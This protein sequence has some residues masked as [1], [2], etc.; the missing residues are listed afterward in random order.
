V[1]NQGYA[2]V[3]AGS[4]WTA[5]SLGT[6]ALVGDIVAVTDSTGAPH[7]FAS[8]GS[9]LLHAT[10]NG[11]Y[12]TDWGAFQTVPNISA[13]QGVKALTVEGKPN[14]CAIGSAISYGVEDAKHP[15]TFI[16]SANV[17]TLQP[18]QALECH[19]TLVFPDR[20]GQILVENFYWTGGM[21]GTTYLYRLLAG[22]WTQVANAAVGPMFG[23]VDGSD[24]YT[25]ITLGSLVMLEREAAPN[26][27]S[28]EA[29]MDATS[30]VGNNVDLSAFRPWVSPSTQKMCAFVVVFPPD[31]SGGFTLPG[32]VYLMEAQTSPPTAD[33]WSFTP[34][35]GAGP[36]I[37][38]PNPLL[39]DRYPRTGFDVLPDPV[40]SL[41]RL[42]ALDIHGN[43]CVAEQTAEGW[44]TLAPT[45][46]Q[47]SA[48]YLIN[49]PQGY[50]QL[51]A[52]GENGLFMLTHGV[53]GG[54]NRTNLLMN[55]SDPATPTLLAIT[56]DGN[57][58]LTAQW[59]VLPGI[60][61]YLVGIFQG[62]Q[63]VAAGPGFG[64]YAI[65]TLSSPFRP[66]SFLQAAVA[67]QTTGAF[68]NRL[69]VVVDAVTGLSATCV[70]TRQVSAQWT[71]PL[72][73][74]VTGAAL[75]LRDTTANATVAEHS[76]SGSSGTLDLPTALNPQHNYALTASGSYGPS[77]GPATAPLALVVVAPQFV[78]AIYRLSQ[79]QIEASLALP[80]P[81][82]CSP[83]LALFGNGNLLQTAQGQ[84]TLVNLVLGG[85]LDPSIAYQVR[86]Y[87]WN[88]NAIG[89]YGPG[90]DVLVTT[91]TIKEVQF[92][93]TAISLE[94]TNLPGPP[95]PT[96]GQVVISAPH[97]NEPDRSQFFI[98]ANRGQFTPT[99][100]LNP[101]TAYAI[102]VA[103][104]RGKS[105]GPFGP[106]LA[107]IAS[108]KAIATVAYDG[109]MLSATW[110]GG[111]GS[112]VTGYLLLVFQ[113]S[114]IIARQAANGSGGGLNVP[115][116]PA[117]VYT[118][119]LQAIG[120]QSSGPIS[121]SVAVISAVPGVSAAV[122]TATT[123]TVT[124]MPPASSAGITQY[125]A[126][127]YRG[128]DQ[129]AS[130]PP[131]AAGASPT[132]VITFATAGQSG[133]AVRV[134]GL[135]NEN[136]SGPLSS[137]IPVLSAPP[138]VE[139]ASIQGNTLTVAWR[140]PAAPAGTIAAS[141]VTITPSQG[142]PIVFPN[143]HGTSAAFTLD[144]N[145][146]QPTLGYNLTI[147]STGPSG[148]TPPSI[149]LPLIP[150]APS[151]SQ[152]AYD[153]RQIIATWQWP[154]GATGANVATGYQ[155]VLSSNGT[156]LQRVEVLGLSGAFTPDMPMGI[157]PSLALSV[158]AFA[159][160][161]AGSAS[162]A[163]ALIQT[164]PTVTAAET[165]AS[166][167]V[168]TVSW[169]AVTFPAA[170]TYLVQ[171]FLGSAPQGSPLPASGTSLALPGELMPAADMAIAVA[172]IATVAGALVTGP[173]GRRFAL[174]TGQPVVTSAD[175]D[176][177]N[178]SAAWAPLTGVAGYV[179]TV[180]NAAHAAVGSSPQTSG[181]TV[182]FP[183][184]LTATDGPFTIV[185]Q[186]VIDGGSG[187]P[188]APLPLFQPALF[189][190]TDLPGTAPPN[191]Y[192]AATLALGATQISI[193]LPPLLQTG[194]DPLV[195]SPVI[196]AFDLQAN[197]DPATKTAFPNVLVFAANSNVWTF[198][199]SEPIRSQLQVQ[200]I[201]FLQAAEAAGASK[202]GISVLQQ[203]ISR[204]MPQTFAESHYYAYGLNLSGGPGTG[205]IDLR[206][207]LVVRV[208]FANYTNVWSGQSNSWLNGFGGGSPADFD[209]ADSVSSAGDWQLSMDSFVA[210]LT[211]SGAMTV[212]PPGSITG[213]GASAGVADPADLFFPTFP[214]PFYRLFFP[215][216]LQ[217]PT[218]TGSIVTEANFALASAASFTALS[219]SSPLPGST[220]PLAYFRGR[221]VL[222]LMIRIRVNGAEVVVPLGTTVGNVLDR[223]G[224]RPPATAIQ[225][226]G[227][228]LERATGPGLAVLGP[229]PQPPS[230]TYD[231]AT[232]RRIRL[233]WSTMANYGGPADA[234]NLPLLHGDRMA[235]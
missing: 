226:T 160:G 123:V 87:W 102:A 94:W 198:I 201:S 80:V 178:V 169:G 189:V 99:P 138:V 219:S 54:W 152:A 105:Q 88:G 205:S 154:A 163:V 35:P 114:A 118:V 67:S 180:L 209:V 63:I 187:L 27:P 47:A 139:Q 50:S 62:T 69:V 28:V 203:A 229:S 111:D 91:P 34:F 33:G 202:W 89:P 121:P 82:G 211:A 171:L 52:V 96:G 177:I 193:Y 207:G 103:S 6:S 61:D 71:L 230:L 117:G 45:R 56:Y 92:S 147:V 131:V 129:V 78:S 183:L 181:T 90:S 213:A 188:S 144:A 3:Q 70:G 20:N 124:I 119:A 184:A 194:T 9:S 130:S 134:Q 75:T 164:Y 41:M 110:P 161:S 106:S 15:G 10:K 65:V 112:G 148:T 44:G 57:L 173:Y 141:T 85:A 174:P 107:V 25:G 77:F 217:D 176:G 153:G 8:D 76:F 5:V 140:L 108:Q 197:T 26:G 126:F 21:M 98:G 224:V 206:Q 128:D 101:G 115:L 125:Q 137:T 4:R 43:I 159:P 48:F 136:I 228:T 113:G 17:I 24:V 215:G 58:T 234:T 73:K 166:T 191:I 235:F 223:Y 149:A 222:R 12:P 133:Y 72:G 214:N 132:A 66:N 46:D 7:I 150:S 16:W 64:R 151:F 86:P 196:G 233:D 97:E 37:I 192:P 143:L 157:D 162:T 38:P 60:N 208:G 168:T 216:Q 84:G 120:L 93:G 22:S 231:S 199:A 186:A 2:V 158:A 170:I 1:T 142:A 232:R 100:A 49:N 190:S 11:P 172:A 227:V 167:G 220:T 155:L 210:M 145:F 127:L 74:N 200:Y 212:S 195:V 42:F 68:G 122:V 40:T 165:N 59:T 204:W 146:L 175:Y 23:F 39:I 13:S 83:G 36:A 31:N 18:Q 116:D 182:A 55:F 135:G 218:G 53:T 179:A 14:L 32:T 19:L 95:Y 156:P 81:D 79:N 225:L 29:G 221:A 185:V 109:R 104:L 51:L 30:I